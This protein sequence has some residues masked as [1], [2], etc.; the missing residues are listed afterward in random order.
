MNQKE[1]DLDSLLKIRTSAET[2]PMRTN[3]VILMSR[4]RMRS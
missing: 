4:H 3:T 1:Q 2:I